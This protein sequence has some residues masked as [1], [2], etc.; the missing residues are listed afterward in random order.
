MIKKG[1]ALFEVDD[2]RVERHSF[3]CICFFARDERVRGFVLGGD[4]GLLSEDFLKVRLNEV[5]FSFV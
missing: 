3:F 1:V 2:K 4:L 5:F